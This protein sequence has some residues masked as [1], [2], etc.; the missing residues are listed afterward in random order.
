MRCDRCEGV[1]RVQGA[2]HHPPC[3]DALR[4]WLTVNGA[5]ESVI[6]PPL[7]LPELWAL[8]A[9][10][11][12]LEVCIDPDAIADPLG[13]AATLQRLHRD[14][15]ELVT[16]G[17]P[18]DKAS[19]RDARLGRR[20]VKIYTSTTSVQVS[21]TSAGRNELMRARF[22]LDV[23]P[24]NEAILLAVRR[25]WALA[26]LGE[27]LDGAERAWA[28]AG[29]REPKLD[30]GERQIFAVA[31]FLCELERAIKSPDATTL[32]RWFTRRGEADLTAFVKC[33]GDG[34]AN[35]PLVVM[36]A[37]EG[38]EGVRIVALV[39]WAQ[40]VGVATWPELMTRP[41]PTIKQIEAVVAEWRGR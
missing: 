7:T 40:Q 2:Y 18:T 22:H 1:P 11:W 21:A 10:A 41:E 14:H 28:L 30:P 35:I 16:F 27:Q 4:A 26:R 17:K 5:G 38:V 6:S 8:S 9:V 37:R 31:I 12:G 29:E 34:G 13:L 20:P 23:G 24:L 19:I 39:R 36:L 25:V 32:T 15:P 33:D 3:L